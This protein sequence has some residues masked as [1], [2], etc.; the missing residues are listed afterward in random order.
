M[1]RI[2]KAALDSFVADE[3]LTH[4]DEA[5]AFEYFSAFA[6]LTPKLYERIAL[7]DVAVGD[8]SLPGIDAMAIVVNGALV[9]SK[10]DLDSILENS[11]SLEVDFHFVQSKT[12]ASFNGALMAD[13]AD[14]VRAFFQDG[15]THANLTELRAVTDK[16]L[17][18][19]TRLKRNPHCHLYY[20][21]TGRWQADEHLIKKIESSRSRVEDVNYFEEVTYDPID[22]L[23]IQRLYRATKNKVSASFTFATKSTLPRIE[24]VEQSYLG[25][26]PGAE[27]LKII[28]DENGDLHRSIFEDNV[29]DFQGTNNPV[30]V[31]IRDS[32]RAHQDQFAVLNNGV[33]IVAKDGK[34]LGDEITLDD[35]QIVNGCQTANVIY[36]LRDELSTI[37]VPLRVVITQDEAIA[38]NITAAT[39]SQTH[40]SK[41]DLY[42]LLNFQRSLEEHF[43]TYDEG[44][45]LY[46][47]RRSQQ[48]QAV[49]STPRNRIVT[50][51]QLV[52]AFAST[53]L[54]EPHRATRYYTTLYR[55]LGERMFGDDHKLEIYY[56]SAVAQYRLEY[57]LRTGALLPYLRPVR[58]H[59]LHA[60]RH[61]AL[62]DSLPDFNSKKLSGVADGYVDTLWDDSISLDLF[63]TAASVVTKVSGGQTFTRDFTK[64]PGLTAGITAEARRS[65]SQLGTAPWKK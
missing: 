44:R 62:G 41:E 9:P 3:Q 19:A 37:F 46:Y 29:R 40:V 21:T 14:E 35:F 50:R 2:T 58:Y 43:R 26:L 57:L 28:A 63:V 36:D 31:K 27:F 22:A 65:R 38:T 56:A 60:A 16:L 30:N 24:G 61:L 8:N 17:S 45:R 59:L 53:F 33:T 47:E 64:Q 20:V 7:E 48:Y 23:A 54:N 32:I 18:S 25:V 1:D 55:Q 13:F 52:K 42:S 51:A 11:G 6:I 5:T 10:D 15:V 49:S 34:V 4:L 12:S 39:N